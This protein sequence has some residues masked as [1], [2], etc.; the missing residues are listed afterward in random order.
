MIYAVDAVICVYDD[1]GKM[2]DTYEHEGDF[3]EP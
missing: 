3:R 2:I 1:G